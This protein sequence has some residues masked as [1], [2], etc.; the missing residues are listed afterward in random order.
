M[1]DAQ[2]YACPDAIIYIMMLICFEL[3]QLEQQSKKTCANLF[4][5]L[6]DV[7]DEYRKEIV[8]KLEE[9]YFSESDYAWSDDKKLNQSQ[10][11]DLMHLELRKS[12]SVQAIFADIIVFFDD[13]QI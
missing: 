9:T 10:F 2:P 7:D 6:C 12:V 4:S 1:D 13:Y 8:P 3:Q 5:T 11:K